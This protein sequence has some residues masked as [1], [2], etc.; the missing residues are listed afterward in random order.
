MEIRFYVAGAQ[1]KAFV[2]AVSELS[3]WEAVYK[4]APSF[5]YAV[6]NY[7]IDKNGTLIIDD[8]ADRGEVSRLLEGLAARG[9]VSG[10]SL[11]ALPYEEDGGDAL[12]ES[13]APDAPD[14]LS[15]ELPLAGFTDAALRNLEKLVASKAG[16]I[17]Q[18][19]GAESLPILRDGERLCFPWFAAD[20]SPEEVAAYTQLVGALCEMAKTQQRI[21]ATER[22]VDNPKYAMRCFLLR[23][24]FIGEEYAAARKLLLKNLSGNSSFKSGARRENPAV[25]APNVA[26]SDRDAP[27]SPETALTGGDYDLAEALA[28]ATLIHEVNALLEGAAYE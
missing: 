15:I 3:G 16:L 10:D 13:A 14:R 21:T 20:S 27:D 26:D 17:C 24:G 6:N 8:G 18:S 4:K 7:I 9:Y 22:A 25:S 1:R 19:I 5:A 11:P 28:D 12:P 2:E 23:L